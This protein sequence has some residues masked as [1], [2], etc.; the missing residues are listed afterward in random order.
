M[1]DTLYLSGGS[2]KGIVY[3]GIINSLN[4]HDVLKNIKNII[5]CSIGSFI[6]ICISI[7][8]NIEI[9]NRII[10]NTKLN[11]DIDNID[12]DNIINNHGLFKNTTFEVILKHLF[13]Y[14]F[15]VTNLT[16]KELYEKTGIN[17]EIK[18][19]NYSTRKTE[20]YNHINNPDIDVALLI[21]AATS[22]PIINEYVNYNDNYLLDGGI[23]GS[24]PILKNKKYKNYIGIW[25]RDNNKNTD[26]NDFI[27]Y[28]N[29]IL[30]NVEDKICDKH[31]CNNKRIL[32]IKLATS[33]IDFNVSEN[34]IN[35]LITT[36]YNNMNKYIKNNKKLFTK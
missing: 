4:E 2:S 21:T 13:L 33:L 7:N 25:L 10:N 18:I 29:F 28:I 22:I 5:S 31:V 6:A 32:T 8:I 24:Y 30:L 27:E 12:L 3:I 23:S 16:I 11:Y 9:L 14:K 17:N 36:G 35:D 1:I 20:Y 34:V 26:K 15:N 19:Y